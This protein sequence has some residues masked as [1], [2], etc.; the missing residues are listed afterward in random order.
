MPFWEDLPAAFREIRRVLRPGGRAYIGGGLGPAR[1]R[2][3]VESA[4]RLHDPRW[5]EKDRNRRDPGEYE[6]ALLAAGIQGGT[7]TRS[8][9]G[10]WIEF[11]RV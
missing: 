8:E 3:R 9:V 11:G 6:E 2:T 1:M 10:T 5:Q 4:L 7:V